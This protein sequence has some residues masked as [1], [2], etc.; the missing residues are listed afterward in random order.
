MFHDYPWK[1]ASDRF[2]EVDTKTISQWHAGGTKTSHG[3][4]PA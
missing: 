3:R 2:C 4:E 1:C